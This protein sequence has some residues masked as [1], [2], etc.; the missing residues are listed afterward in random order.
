[1]LK[2]GRTNCILGDDV[3]IVLLEGK[4]LVTIEEQP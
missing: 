2:A 4:N 3:V 1:M